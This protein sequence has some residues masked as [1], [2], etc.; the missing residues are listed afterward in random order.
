LKPSSSQ[1][2]HAKTEHFAVAYWR[3]G[4]TDDDKFDRDDG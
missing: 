2:I 3:K 1:A 4:K